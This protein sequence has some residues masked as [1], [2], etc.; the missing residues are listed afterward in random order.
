MPVADIAIAAAVAIS[1]LVGF[2]RGFVKE[3]IS[4]SALLV[5]IWAS[6]NFGDDFGELTGSWLSSVE[7]QVWFGRVLVFVVIIIIGG[8]VS[9]AFAK[10]VRLSVLSG[11]DRALGMV[12]GLGRGAL[13]AGVFALGGQFAN[14]D[15]ARWWRESRLMPYATF[16]ADWLR[17]MAPRGFE[18]MQPNPDAQLPFDL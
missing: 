13:L 14:F 3:A 11:T 9:W 2:L 18:M 8:L 1:V 15:D 5:A 17:V 6:L 10:L 4:V 7:L 16:V 12:F